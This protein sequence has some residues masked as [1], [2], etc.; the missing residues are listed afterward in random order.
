MYCS[1]FSKSRNQGVFGD[2][3]AKTNIPAEV[4]RY[5]L[6]I[7]RPENSDTTFDWQDFQ[8][9][10]NNG[11]WVVKRIGFSLFHLRFLFLLLQSC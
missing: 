6:L 10:N 4:W 1:K 5:Y 11:D 3:A 8:N 2:D 7:N 9:K